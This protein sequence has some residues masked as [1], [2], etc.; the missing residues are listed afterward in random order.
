MF[1]SVPGPVPMDPRETVKAAAAALIRD[2]TALPQPVRVTDAGGGLACMILVW[3]AGEA[4]PTLR[5]GGRR[6]GCR[7]D[8]L[9]AVRAAGRPLTRKELVRALREA[10]TPHGPGT[11]AKALAELTAGGELV[12]PKDKRGYRLPAWVRKP[13]PSLFG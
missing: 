13:T 2:L 5:R 12:N 10:K 11:V 8:L 9:A 1:P 3:P 6:S 4:M 7:G